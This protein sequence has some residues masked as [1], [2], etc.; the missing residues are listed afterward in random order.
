[1]DKTEQLLNDL[2]EWVKQRRG[3]QR[4]VHETLGVSKQ[5]VSSWV[6]G[7]GS[8]NFGIGLR[9]RAFLDSHKP[10]KPKKAPRPP[11]AN[12]KPKAEPSPTIDGK[13]QSTSVEVTS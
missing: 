12:G 8:P 11:A 6:Q 9:L 4:L 1:M 13:A 2:R 5:A 3:N 10:G 7:R